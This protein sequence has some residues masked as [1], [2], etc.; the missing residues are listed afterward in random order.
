MPVAAVTYLPDPR[1]DAR[2]LRSSEAG[3]ERTG[4]KTAAHAPGSTE[5]RLPTHV[6]VTFARASMTASPFFCVWQEARESSSEAPDC[7]AARRKRARAG[8]GPGKRAQVPER[9]VEAPAG[10]VPARPYARHVT[11]EPAFTLPTA[12]GSRTWRRAV[13]RWAPAP[14]TL[15]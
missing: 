10:T 14:P 4:D 3:E 6:H 5:R 8:S 11:N 15:A 2:H 12:N 1:L 9:W 7:G 13:G